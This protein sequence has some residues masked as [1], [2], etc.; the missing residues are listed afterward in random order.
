MGCF[1]HKGVFRSERGVWWAK[2]G[3]WWAKKSVWGRTDVFGGKKGCR[4]YNGV[5]GVQM[6]CFGVFVGEQV[7]LGVKRCVRV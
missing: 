3:V 5:F 2:I 1:G 7:C 4:A 6:E